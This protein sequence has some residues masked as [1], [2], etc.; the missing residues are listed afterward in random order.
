MHT[1]NSSVLFF[2]LDN[3][4]AEEDPA[5]PEE[6]PGEDKD[7]EL[8]MTETTMLNEGE[9]TMLRRMCFVVLVCVCV[10]VCVC[11]CM[12]VCMC[13]CV[14]VGDTVEVNTVQIYNWQ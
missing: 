13:T 8:K 2:F 4:T 7:E 14:Y 1:G 5:P 10:C 6:V 11:T 3:E 9:T 12:C